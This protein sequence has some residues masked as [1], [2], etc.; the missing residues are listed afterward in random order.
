MKILLPVPRKLIMVLSIMVLFAHFS[1]AQTFSWARQFNFENTSFYATRSGLDNTGNFYSAGKDFV[2]KL[3]PAGIT[4]WSL[5][6]SASNDIFIGTQTTD[7][8]GNIYIS[9]YYSGTRNFNPKGTVYN[10]SATGINDCFVAKYDT[11]GLLLWAITIGGT[12]TEDASSVAVDAAGN[13]IITGKFNQTCDFDPGVG[14]YNLTSAGQYDYF[15]EKLDPSGNFLWVKS[16]ENSANGNGEHVVVDAAQNVFVIGSFTG[17]MSFDGINT[18]STS[19]SNV[20]NF[21]EKLDMNGNHVWVKQL[22]TNCCFNVTNMKADAEGNI[23]AC[24]YFSGTI[25]VDPGTAIYNLNGPGA[26]NGCVIK[27]SNDGNLVWGKAFVSSGTD[28]A[29]GMAV[30]GY[31]NVYVTG[32]F[33]GTGNHDF[34]PG[35]ST[36][37]MSCGATHDMYLV[38]LNSSGNFR[39]AIQVGGG[40]NSNAGGYAAQVNPAGQIYVPVNINGTVDFD[41]SKAKYNL[42]STSGKYAV[43]K[44]TQSNGGVLRGEENVE[45]SPSYSLYPNPSSGSF[46]V[47]FPDLSSKAMISISDMLGREVYSRPLTE[48]E[49]LSGKMKVELSGKGNYILVLSDEKTRQVFKLLV[50]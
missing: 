12:G 40:S 32:V 48:T 23:Y 22:V 26:Q 50:Q 42:V 10:L 17:S 44:L 1:H 46:S 28:Q 45:I 11:D 18:V 2:L 39:W 25:D 6:F 27:Y 16:A 8:S 24:A 5:Q 13:V 37:N 9:G 14:V 41:P 30:D 49:K 35:P 38:K 21:M 43:L 19:A 29:D 34:D 3:S 7:P 47:T 36:Y 33:S 15:V 20:S 4:V 31:G